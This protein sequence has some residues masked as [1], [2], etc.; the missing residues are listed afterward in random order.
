MAEY[1]IAEKEPNHFAV[2]KYEEETKLKSEYTVIQDEMGFLC[3][4]PRW[5]KRKT[6]SCRHTDMV[7][8]WL[9][10]GKPQPYIKEIQ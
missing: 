6:V 3:N 5:L 1:F 8:D 2:S 7:L 4:C 10:L 9:K